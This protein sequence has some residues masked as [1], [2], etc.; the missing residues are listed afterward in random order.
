MSARG[1]WF[2]G[3]GSLTYYPNNFPFYYYFISQNRLSIELQNILNIINCILKNPFE[4][5]KR[6]KSMPQKWQVHGERRFIRINWTSRRT[7]LKSERKNRLLLKSSNAS[8]QIFSQ[9][10]I[11][12]YSRDIHQF[13]WPLLLFHRRW[14]INRGW[15]A[16]E[17]AALGVVRLPPRLHIYVYCISRLPL[18]SLEF[19]SS[20][21]LVPPSLCLCLAVVNKIW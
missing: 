3:Y 15:I 21:N 18:I 12:A 5:I 1:R 16:N 19:I 6:L 20:I 11:S 4:R 10:E 17:A 14:T 9:L 2:F 13:N 8:F 7:N